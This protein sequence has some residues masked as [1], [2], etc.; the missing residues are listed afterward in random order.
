MFVPRTAEG[1][2]ST[3]SALRS[4]DVGEGVTFYTFDI[5][6]GSLLRLLVKTLGRHMPEGIVKEELE[7]FGISVQGVLQLR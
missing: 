7:N 2:R 5:P 1:F 4:L 3:V 6:L